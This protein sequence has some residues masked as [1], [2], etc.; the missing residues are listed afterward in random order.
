[1]YVVSIESS[2]V[3]SCFSYI[4]LAFCLIQHILETFLVYLSIHQDHHTGYHLLVHQHG[5]CFPFLVC[6]CFKGTL[7]RPKYTTPNRMCSTELIRSSLH[8]G[9]CEIP[10]I[11]AELISQERCCIHAITTQPRS[12]LQGG[13]KFCQDTP[14]AAKT[15]FTLT[16]N[17]IPHFVED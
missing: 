11:Y 14:L 4:A 9:N 2:Q 8:F 7:T 3:R 12:H 17:Q 16:I 15:I 1:M 6:L 5:S 10:N 13:L